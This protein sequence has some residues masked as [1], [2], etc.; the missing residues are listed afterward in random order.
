MDSSS[1]LV[2][3]NSCRADPEVE[4]S[5]K[6]LPRFRVISACISLLSDTSRRSQFQHKQTIAFLLMQRFGQRCQFGVAPA[7]A[8][9]PG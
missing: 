9:D 5:F 3:E 7:F 8:S 1:L 2:W 4:M 6:R